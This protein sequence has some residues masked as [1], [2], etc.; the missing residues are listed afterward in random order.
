MSEKDKE[1]ERLRKIGFVAA[2]K[3][4]AEE[5]KEYNSYGVGVEAEVQD[6]AINR[7]GEE[8]FDLLHHFPHLL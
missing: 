3:E 5:W 8:L 4:L 1:T 7:C 6:H 2:V